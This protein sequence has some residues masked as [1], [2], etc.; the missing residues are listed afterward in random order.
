[1]NRQMRENV[2]LWLVC[3]IG[4]S[5]GLMILG[6]KGPTTSQK[7]PS[8]SE[9]TQERG[10]LLAFAFDTASAIPLDP[11]KKDRARA[12][13]KVVEAC[14][15]AGQPDRAAE[16][17]RKIAN[18][19]QGVAFGEL[20]FAMAKQGNTAKCE[21]F[22]TA[23]SR[24]AG[25][26]QGWRR[27]R[28]RVRI[29]RAKALLGQAEVAEEMARHVE[30]SE[31]GKLVGITGQ[32]K[33]D[34]EFEKELGQIQAAIAKRNFDVTGNLQKSLVELYDAKYENSTHRDSIEDA[35]NA[36]FKQ[37]PPIVRVRLTLQLADIALKHHDPAKATESVN[38]A[39]AIVDEFRWR[40]RYWIPLKSEIA[41]IRHEAGEPKRGK[42]AADAVLSR[43]RKDGAT[44]TDIYRAE[45]LHPLAEAYQ[46]MGEHDKAMI[47][48]GLAVKE[49]LVNPNSRPRA[50]DL[51]ATCCSM[52][53]HG[54]VPSA[55][56]WERMK[57]IRKGLKTPW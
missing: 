18:W 39:E 26:Y 15:K 13:Q 48:Y 55:D 19:R 22:L 29:A 41:R 32:A 11:H 46:R 14:L 40:L 34:T 1:M 9:R 57:E 8:A 30:D 4:L 5:Y 54:V 16:Y 27:D 52:A 23:A 49:L 6:C 50:I 44:I 3:F 35:I 31:T 28:I 10:K 21:S 20:A 47:V 36:S 42:A 51:S 7:E 45:T 38:K 53:V 12:Q 2:F 33:D 25:Q 56:L 24:V 17:A 43:Y 37:V